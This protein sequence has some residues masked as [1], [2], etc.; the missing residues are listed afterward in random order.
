MNV[1]FLSPAFPIEMPHFVAALAAVGARVFAVGEQPEAALPDAAKEHLTAYVQVS[2][3]MNEAEV[4][5]TVHSQASTHGVRFDRVE[6]L[7]EPLMLLAARLREVLSVPGMTVAQTVPFRDKETM[8]QVLDAAGI[9]TPRHYRC[10]SAS[11]VREAAGKVGY[12]LIVKPID[13]AGSADTHRVDEPSQLESVLSSI[14]HVPEVSVEEF[15]DGEEFTFDTIC[16]Q[17]KVLFHNICWYRPRPLIART[18]EWM[19]SQTIALRDPNDDYVKSGCEM[20]FRVL[21]ALGFTDGYTHMEWFRKPDGEAVFGEIGARPPG[22][23][24]VETMSF[25]ADFDCYRGW[26]EATC[27]G[28]FTQPVQRRYNASCIFKRARGQGRIEAVHGMERYLQKYGEHVIRV[29]MLPVGAQRRNWLATLLSDGHI[30]LRHPDLQATLQMSDAFG[31][32]VW[33]EA[34]A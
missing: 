8:K 16:A 4:I 12:P 3:I 13:G 21:D 9:R 11:S 32:E 19:D 5:A 20:G 33:I 18:V 34:G 15:I 22:A 2:S 25:A 7:W 14:G 1:L 29:D 28:H 30:V 6:C 27:L 26:A 23:L 10:D 31:S 24:T 17:D